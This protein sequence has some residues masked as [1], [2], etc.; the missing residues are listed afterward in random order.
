[1]NEVVE[2]IILSLKSGPMSAAELARGLRVDATT[3]TRR[4][5]R[6]GSQVIKAGEG[7]ATRW[8]LRRTL[9]MLPRQS[10]LPIY[11]VNDNGKAE[12]IALLHIVYPD[13]SY[14]A[15]ITITARFCQSGSSMSRC[16]GG[17]LI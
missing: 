1:M 16:H 5:N 14:F 8:L 6:L 7:R 9:P 4:L 3:V 10:V 15:R 17:Y 13:D 12:K 2:N 11:R